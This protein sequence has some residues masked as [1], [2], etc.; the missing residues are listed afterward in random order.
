MRVIH[1]VSSLICMLLLL[2]HCAQTSEAMSIYIPKLNRLSKRSAFRD[3]RRFAKHA[4]SA[5]TAGKTALEGAGRKLSRG[6]TF[7]LRSPAAT[8]FFM[9]VGLSKEVIEHS[10][11]DDMSVLSSGAIIINKSLR[12]PRNLPEIVSF[13]SENALKYVDSVV[14]VGAGDFIARYGP[15]T[16]SFL[17]SMVR[18]KGVVNV[19]SKCV[20]NVLCSSVFSES[21]GRFAPM[22]CTQLY[23]LTVK[24]I[25]KRKP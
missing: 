21:A 18:E 13:F 6:V 10:S 11:S 17:W 9:D 8:Q 25:V 19:G 5:A 24:P 16:F 22:I 4:L 23:D 1:F 12:T 7:A 3:I 2:L 14:C 15:N 20:F